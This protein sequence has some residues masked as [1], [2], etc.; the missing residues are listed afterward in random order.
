MKKKYL[1]PLALFAVLAVV[2]LGSG[3]FR[4][5]DK[6]AT[7]V[8]IRAAPFRV[9]S[10]YEGSL[11]SRTVRNVMS[12]LGGPA[13]VVEIV[14]EGSRVK[15][16][17]LLVKFDAAQLERDAMKQEKEQAL[18]KANLVS[19]ENAKLPLELRDLETR[20]A[21]ARSSFDS[22][23][24]Y[25]E[26]SRQLLSE[27]LISSQEVKQQELKVAA[28]KAQVEGLEMQLELT[29]K[30]LH[31]TALDAAR[32]TLAS[33]EQELKFSRQ[34]LENSTVRSPADGMVVY[35]PVYVGGEFR[36]ARVG[37]TIYR[38]QP[39]MAVPD[40]DN[41]I[42]QC[43]VPEAELARVKIGNE[44]LVEPLAYPGMKLE[45]VVESVGSMAQSVVNRADWLKFFHV[46]IGLKKTDPQLRSGMSVRI[47]IL[48]Y[49]NEAALLIPRAAVEWDNG[50]PFCRLARIGRSVRRE[51]T[52]G[53]ADDQNFE[54]VSGL[55][56]GD[57]V[58][59]K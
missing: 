39:F 28:A 18:A 40:M 32:A 56:D 37:D 35:K 49:R 54:V 52:L 13:A 36:T 22:E 21:E 2:I 11:E 41:P 57:R 29:Q 12:S 3:T 27:Q 5:S 6:D 8:E 59:V 46:T 4:T 9:W 55:E 42:V 31:P 14:P 24:R 25:L 34:Q 15:K 10:V 47:R 44:V 1:V 33:A 16:G 53:M 17:D 45:G 30:Y 51:L 48:S 58:V 19:L 38:S 43:D 50:N 20:L 23:S 26:D 7:I